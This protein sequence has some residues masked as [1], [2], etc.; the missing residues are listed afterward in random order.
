VGSRESR[1]DELMRILV[2]ASVY[3]SGHGNWL[4][5]Q[6][7][8]LRSAGV[9]VDVIFFDPRETRLNYAYSIPR[10]VRAVAS[11]RY[12]LI[13]V[14]HTY[15]MIQVAIAKRLVGSSIPVV[16]TQH[17]PETL[18]VS[19]RVRTWHP[20]SQLRYSIR[21]KRL[22][23]E[24]AEFVIFVAKRLAD[25]LASGRPHAI[26]PCGVD[27]EKFRP[28]SREECRKTL[29]LPQD[30]LVV[31][32]PAPPHKPQKHFELARR[33]FEMVQR[34]RPAA[35]LIT[36]GM[37]HADE[38]PVYYNAANV[39]LQTSFC[40]AS[41]TVVKEALA[42]EVP[43]VST[44]AGD[45]REVVE[46]VPHCWVCPEDPET[47]SRRILQINGH[48]SH[49]GRARLIESG[50]TLQQVAARVIRAYEAVLGG[51]DSDSRGGRQPR[52]VWN[53]A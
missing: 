33:T 47:L 41:P 45:T 21:L 27:L 36:G 39:M 20:S 26:I 3:L 10:I 9:D 2:V 11:K 19:G 5:E 25:A 17:E 52:E 22:A 44:D 37:I 4:A 18:D 15:T 8:S 13:H 31:F 6:V 49:G 12:Q 53:S 38:M 48:R 1:N 50:L 34:Q 16:L 35:Y 42:C 43:V 30:E 24:R 23:V 51:P 28:L 7:R 40:E 46:S 32:F 14:H 29:G